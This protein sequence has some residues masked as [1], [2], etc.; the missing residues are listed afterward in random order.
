MF[1]EPHHCARYALA[2]RHHLLHLLPQAV[3]QLLGGGVSQALVD[4]QGGAWGVR[5]RVEGRVRRK[6]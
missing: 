4:L 6:E 5:E 3:V 1:E 2:C